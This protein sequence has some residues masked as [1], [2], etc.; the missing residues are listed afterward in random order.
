MSEHVNVLS[1]AIGRK[2]EEERKM[3]REERK[4]QNG[5]RIRKQQRPVLNSDVL[6]RK[7]QKCLQRPNHRSVWRK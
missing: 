3:T 2:H 4:S 7:E 6:L 1:E 5:R